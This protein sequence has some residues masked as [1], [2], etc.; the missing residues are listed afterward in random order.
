MLHGSDWIATIVVAPHATHVAIDG[1]GKLRF[2]GP[3]ADGEI[4]IQPGACGVA[5]GIPPAREQAVAFAA[6]VTNRKV[7]EVPSRFLPGV[8]IGPGGAR[9]RVVLDEL[10]TVRALADGALHETAEVYVAV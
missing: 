8:H 10:V 3:W 5:A 7:V 2:H 4:G 9:W 1:N 6:S